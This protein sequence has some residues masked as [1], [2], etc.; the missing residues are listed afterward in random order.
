[1]TVSADEW[2]DLP[3]DP[4]ILL[5][6]W[7]PGNDDPARPLMTVAT[8]DED[9][10]PDA[11]SLLL[12]EWDAEGFY[13]HTDARSRKVAQVT[14][15]SA[16]ALC[17]P[18]LGTPTPET[19]H[20]LVVRGRAEPASAPEQQRAYEARPRYLQQLAWQNTPEFATLPQA[21]RIAAWADFADAQATG[22]A[23]PPTWIGYLV[24]PERLTFWFGSEDTASRRIEYTRRGDEWERRILAG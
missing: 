9:G 21:E 23:P 24:R 10:A 6:A 11:R 18:L 22:F 15:S 14:R 7:L 13:W 17:L 19:R 12:S 2:D 1:M 5:T 3:D 4:S 20:Q 16:V 8:V